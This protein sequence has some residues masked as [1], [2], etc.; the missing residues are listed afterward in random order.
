MAVGAPGR[1]RGFPRNRAGGSPGQGR[2]F[3]RILQ[4]F[5]RGWGLWGALGGSRG[6]PGRV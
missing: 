5:P 1:G 2:G 4:G 6:G 3:S